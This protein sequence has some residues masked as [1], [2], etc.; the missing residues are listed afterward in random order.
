MSLLSPETDRRILEVATRLFTEQGFDAVH[1]DRIAEAANFGK[2]SIYRYYPTKAQLWEKALANLS[3]FYLRY[4]VIITSGVSGCRVRLIEFVRVTLRFLSE[5][6]LLLKTF[7]HADVFRL[8]TGIVAEGVVRR[9]FEVSD[10]ELTVRAL[11]GAVQLQ[12]LQP[13]TEMASESVPVRLVDIVTSRVPAVRE[14]R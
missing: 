6:P 11:V 1:M 8:L 3:D 10:L 13:C 7:P 9:E 4:V 5:N 12:H 2:A 14:E